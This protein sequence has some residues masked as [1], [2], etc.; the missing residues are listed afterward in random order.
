[1]EKGGGRDALCRYSFR[2]YCSHIWVIY[3]ISIIAMDG[4]DI[5]DGYVRDPG[6][7]FRDWLS[8]DW[9]QTK[10]NLALGSV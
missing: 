3:D 10:R 7:Y 6:N 8:L 5:M 1:M 4:G 9:S 2:C